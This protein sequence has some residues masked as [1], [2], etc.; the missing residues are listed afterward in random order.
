MKLQ[1]DCQDVSRLL[2]RQQDEAL[3]AAER[4]R[5][6]L[7]LVICQTCRNVDEQLAFIRRAMARLGS[8]NDDAPPPPALRG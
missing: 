2:S 3:P 8:D 1:L 7:H 4:A 5:L 6:R